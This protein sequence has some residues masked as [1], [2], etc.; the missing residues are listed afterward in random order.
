MTKRSYSVRAIWDDEAGVYYSE[1][2]I[3]GLHIETADLDEF[4]A[5]L[6]EVG[7]GLVLA[8]HV[9]GQELLS[10]PLKDLIPAIVW[11]RPETARVEA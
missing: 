1:S 11:Q 3:I 7:P 10:T 2:D 6:F 4:E 8:N 9:S 5:G